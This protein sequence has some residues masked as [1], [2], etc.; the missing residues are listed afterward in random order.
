[1]RSFFII[2]ISENYLGRQRRRNY[3]DFV[4]CI[5]GVLGCFLVYCGV[6][7][8]YFGC[9]GAYFGAFLEFFGVF[10]F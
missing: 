8:M 2:L 1:M 4:W 9:F 10:C 3:G 5:F 6:F 7:L